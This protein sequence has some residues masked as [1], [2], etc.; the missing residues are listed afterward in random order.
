MSKE[1]HRKDLSFDFEEMLKHYLVKC[2]NIETNKNLSPELEIR[3]GTNPKIAKPI[4]VIDYKH[5]VENLLSN[6]WL[7][8]AHDMTGKQMLRI[9]PERYINDNNYGKKNEINKNTRTNN[10]DETKN[11]KH[12]KGDKDDKDDMDDNDKKDENV[13]DYKGLDENNQKGGGRKNYVM[14]KIRAELEGKTLIQKYC[15]SNDLNQLKGLSGIKFT[16]KN[17]IINQETGKPFKN[18]DFEDFNFRVA[19]MEEEDYDFNYTQYIPIKRL[20][21]DWPTSKKTYRSINRVR[22]RHLDYPVFVDVSMI[23]TNRKNKINTRKNGHASPIPTETIQESGVFDT[24]PIFEIELELDNTRMSSYESNKKGVD[25]LMSKIKKCIRFVLSGLQETPYPVSYNE[26]K[27]I[28]DTY[29]CRIH[30]DSWLNTRIPTPYFIGPQSV[31]IQLENTIH[32]E[33]MLSSTISIVK[34]YTVTEKADGQR[35]L[36]YVSK[37]GK[38]FMISNNLK[39]MFT[40]SITKEKL[41]FDSLLDGEYILHGKPP[42][43]DMIFLYAAFDIYY[44]GG[45]QKN[46]HVRDL[47][48]ATN[49]DT[50]LEDKYRLSLLE[51]FSSLFKV[52]Q[53]TQNAK[54]AFR[55]RCKK[56][57]TYREN[58]QTIF[59][60]SSLVLNRNYEYEVDGLIFTPMNL[61]VGGDNPG[62]ANTLGK[63]FT[64][65]HSF[66][67]KPPYYNTID[68][69]VK[70]KKGDDGQDLIK[71][72]ANEGTDTLK[73]IIPYKTL[74]LNVGFDKKKHKH[75]NVFHDVLYDNDEYF[76]KLIGQDS[77]SN[78]EAMPFVP[79]EPYDPEAYICHIEL[80][81]D[82]TRKL[83]MKTVEGDV[84]DENMVV[85]F[86]YLK[87]DN[88]KKGPWKWV[89]LR[90]RQDKTQALREGMKSMNNY[91]TADTNWKSIHLPIT[92][93]MICGEEEIPKIEITDAVYYNITK[94]N[95]STTNSL[96]VFHNYV[97]RKLISNISNHLRKRMNISEPIL[98]DFSVGKGGDL[99][100]WTYSK[101]KF[102]LGIDYHGDNITNPYNGACIRYLRERVRNKTSSL[103]A[104]FVEGNSSLNIRTQGTAFNSSMEKEL[105]QSIFGHGKNT[106]YKKYVFKHG[107]A[108]EG[109]HISSCQFSLHYFF[110]NSKTLHSFLKNVA[111]CTRLHG[112]FIGTCFDGEEVFK[113]LHKRSNG[114][115]I[116]KNESIRIDKNG[117]KMFEVVKKYNSM[118][119]EFKPDET[120]IGLPIQV[121]QESIDKSFTEYLVNFEY[122]IQLMEN[123]GFVL[124]EKDELRSIGFRES[125]AL[126]KR[127]YGLLEQDM[128]N[129]NDVGDF[130][131]ATMMTHHEKTVS[132]LNRYFIF[133][134]VRELS[135]TTLTQMNN[136]IQEE[137][138]SKTEVVD[139]IKEDEIPRKERKKIKKI[140]VTLNE[141]N[142]SPLADFDDPQIQKFYEELP[143]KKKNKMNALSHYDKEIWVKYLMKKK[144]QN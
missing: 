99:S 60:A 137:E 65:K 141:D 85:E 32:D 77:E 126:F 131:D 123:Y 21:Y 18:I 52:E 140:K 12:D 27:E 46:A 128:K 122:L 143:E 71:Y 68:F 69:L 7:S 38:I 138:E 15:S 87:D 114:T 41:C 112:Y 66:K 83:R 118:I 31:P 98:I 144:Q 57:E 75:M 72:I 111:E 119:Q 142:Y 93:K 8:E 97:K 59:E 105:V 108:N 91:T 26:Q 6:G 124:L 34:D 113:F 4:T 56:F 37:N 13:E 82:S 121:F 116:K 16:K 51:K 22:F 106:N 96:R 3:F 135:T 2:D 110:E 133:K 94:K 117:K 42:N 9:I 95:E 28:I 63:K 73:N 62:Q 55:F 44:F 48:F 5:V 53:V 17:V 129:D 132:F 80:E 81:E 134:K 29:M 84:F 1:T 14:S 101:I 19:Y 49:D 127:F 61:G 103:R 67:W 36:L 24:P 40:G 102:V 79:T 78:Y 43:K 109:F 86:Q 130:K 25:K 58:E 35:A 125:T 30:T 76:T 20:L 115:L 10:A 120:S 74:I 100:K 47:P 139:K 107:I 11:N 92:E 50:A 64:W 23:K 45:M 33:T 89:P 54:C 104:L 136:I 90:V 39:V 70:T 88:M